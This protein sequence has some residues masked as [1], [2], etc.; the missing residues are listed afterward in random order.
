MK[1]L[2]FALIL[3]VPMLF[4]Y[5]CATDRDASAAYNNDYVYAVGYYNKSPYWGNNYYHAGYYGPE[6][7]GYWGSYGDYDRY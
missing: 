7:Y 6:T 1:K 4:L 2:F 3:S 5:G